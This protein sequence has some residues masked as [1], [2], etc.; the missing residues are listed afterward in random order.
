MAEKNKGKR[1]GGFASM[2][3]ARQREIASM[4]GRAAHESGN[5]H[6]FTSEEARIA[7]RKGGEAPHVDR[8]SQ[9]ATINQSLTTSNRNERKEVDNTKTV[10]DAKTTTSRGGAEQHVDT[11]TQSHSN[12]QP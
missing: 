4:G 7:G 12:S 3:A 11:G 10:K 6:E 5:A 2:D 1:K 8:G 9:A